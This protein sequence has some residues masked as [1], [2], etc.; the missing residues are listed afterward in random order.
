MAAGVSAA[1]AGAAGA[2]AAA[3]AGGAAPAGAVVDLNAATAAD[4]DRLP[5][6]GPVLAQR[7]VDH[8][9]ANGPFRSV[10]Q[11]REVSGIGEAKYASLRDLVR[12]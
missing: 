3:G 2:G 4:L 6:I 9:T 1:G 7:I 5:G 8:R 10:D 11:L 12:V